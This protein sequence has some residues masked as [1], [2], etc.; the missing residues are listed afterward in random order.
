MIQPKNIGCL[1]SSSVFATDGDQWPT[2][3]WHDNQ[4]PVGCWRKKTDEYQRQLMFFGC[5]IWANET[6]HW[7]GA[8]EQK[9]N[10]RSE[11]SGK[12]RQKKQSIF[13]HYVLSSANFS[14]R[15]CTNLASWLPLAASKCRK[16][17]TVSCQS[18]SS[19]SSSVN[20]FWLSLE[21]K[22]R[23]EDRQCSLCVLDWDRMLK[24]D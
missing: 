15:D 17:Y 10:T 22:R 1:W 16:S 13:C 9:H 21:R 2:S 11:S 5:I 12:A 3:I 14:L 20:K 19:F 4:W 8:G 6:M 24:T 7:M 23:A 18:A